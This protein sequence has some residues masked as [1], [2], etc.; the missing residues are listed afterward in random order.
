[1]LGFPA[2]H[3]ETFLVRPRQVPLR[4]A[5][6]A[7]FRSLSWGLQSASADCLVCAT[8][9]NVWSWGESV[10]VTVYSDGHVTALSKCVLPLQLMDWGKNYENIQ[11]LKRVL[12][13]M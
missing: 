10:R 13:Q 9:M 8:G 6:L 12:S 4:D 5:V 11:S 2:Y 7:A 1:M 3:E